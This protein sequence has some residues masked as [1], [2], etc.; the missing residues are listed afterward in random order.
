MRLQILRDLYWKLKGLYWSFYA[1]HN[2]RQATISWYKRRMNKEPNL[3]KPKTLT[4]KLQYLKLNDYFYNPIVTQCADKYAVRE[5]VK[6]CGCSEILNE[7]YYVFNS[8]DEINWS[9]LPKQFVLKCNHGCG[10]NILCYD[11]STL[12][13]NKAKKDLHK[14]LHNKYGLDHVE[15]SYENIPPK[16]VCEKLIKSEDGFPPRDYK[17]FCSYGEPKLIYTIS[18]RREHTECL[19]YFTPDWEW[20]PVKNGVLPNAKIRPGKPEKLK[21]MLEYASKLSKDFPIVRVDLYCEFGQIL[22]GELTFLATGGCFKL[23]PSE[24][25]DIF[26]RFFPLDNII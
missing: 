2:P 9:V 19:D 25:D 6:K 13:I 8:V 18:E 17:I 20:I 24:Y 21:E 22:F 23:T 26:G 3:D 7:L 12:N 1:K 11:K 15:F 10:G 4:E 5:Y 16:I 14:W